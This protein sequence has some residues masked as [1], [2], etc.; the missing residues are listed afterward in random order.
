YQWEQIAELET[1]LDETLPLVTCSPSE[2]HQA[3]INIL[4]NAVQAL[5]EQSKQ[6]SGKIT[7]SSRRQQLYAELAIS[8]NGDGIPESAQEKIFNPFFTTRDVGEGTGQGLTLSHDIVVRKHNGKL[9]FSTE[10]GFGTTFRLQL[11]LDQAD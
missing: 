4:M 10:A 6:G 1:D 8:D 3:L 2:M 7:I 5:E 9:D 11:P